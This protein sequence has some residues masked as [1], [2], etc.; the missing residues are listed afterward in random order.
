MKKMKNKT[1]F[2]VPFVHKKIRRQDSFTIFTHPQTPLGKSNREN[3]VGR[4]CGTHGKEQKSVQGFGGKDQ[5]KEKNLK[6]KA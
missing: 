4:A 6:T 2:A 5:G 1:K 3:E